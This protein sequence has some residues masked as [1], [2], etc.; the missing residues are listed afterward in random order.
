[1]GEAEQKGEG[2]K[3]DG[4]HPKLKIEDRR[5]TKRA[6]TKRGEGRIQ[7]VKKPK[8]SG[9]GSRKRG[10]KRLRQVGKVF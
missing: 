4:C 3:R 7:F 1:M 8:A 10:P 2:R 5:F 9:G 6:S